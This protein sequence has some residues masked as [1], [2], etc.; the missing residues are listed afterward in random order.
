MELFSDSPD[1]NH[2]FFYSIFN[3]R[4]AFSD[5]LRFMCFSYSISISSFHAAEKCV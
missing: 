4:N 1:G 2:T 5:N 3:L